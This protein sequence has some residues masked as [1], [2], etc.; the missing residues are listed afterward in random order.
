MISEDKNIPYF[1]PPKATNCSISDS[2]AASN[3]GFK[4]SGVI[5]SSINELTIFPKA[6]PITTPIAKSITLP[7]IAKALNSLSIPI[8]YLFYDILIIRIY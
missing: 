2:F 7:F 5:T 8:L 1:T 3:A 6:A 4:M